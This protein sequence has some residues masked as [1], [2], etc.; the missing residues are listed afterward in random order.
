[1]KSRIHLYVHAVWAVN[2]RKTLLGR[3]VRVVLFSHLR[4]TAEE[5]GI[6]VL[7]TGGSDDHMHV[8]LQLHPAQNLAQVVRQLKS[9]SAEWL[10]ATKV[11]GEPLEWEE[12]YLAFSV[13]PNVLRQVADYLE[14]QDEYHRKKSL[15]E[16]LELFEKLQSGAGGSDTNNQSP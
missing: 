4:K 7:A 10:N 9:E 14:K 1:M 3:T 6:R 8:L 11:V 2:G 16:E 13:S 12:D 15:D 5:K